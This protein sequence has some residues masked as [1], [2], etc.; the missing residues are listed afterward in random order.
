MSAIGQGV[1]LICGNQLDGFAGSP[2]PAGLAPAMFPLNVANNDV[3][4]V[5]HYVRRKA[6]QV[7]I[8][9][10]DGNVQPSD[11]FG[12][13]GANYFTIT[14]TLSGSAAPDTISIACFLPTALTKSI[15][16]AI[17]WQEN[18]TE[19][20]L[21]PVGSLNSQGTRSVTVGTTTVTVIND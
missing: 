3:I 19:A 4:T 21:I 18:S 6:W 10:A 15:F 14:Q 1:S 20:S 7:I 5:S 2:T 11:G 13:A 9:D 16:V 12:V 17:R 8:T